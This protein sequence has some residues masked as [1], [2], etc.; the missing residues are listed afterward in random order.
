MFTGQAI[1][2]REDQRL[3]TGQGSYTD[4]VSLPGS[5]HLVFVRSPHAHARILSIDAAAAR[6]MAGVEA[7]VTGADVAHLPSTP[8]WM[9]PP[10]ANAPATHPLAQDRVRYVGE[11]VAAVLARD[12]YLARDAADAIE[13]EYEP[14]AAV[15]DPERALDGGSPRIHDG[16]DSNLAFR[17]QVGSDDVDGALAAADEV[18]R[19]RIDHPRVAALPLEPRAVVARYDAFNDSLEVVLST[20]Y[21]HSD[22][23][24]LAIVLGIPETKVRVITRD[25][26]GAFGA[27]GTVY[28]EEAIAAY[29]AWTRRCAVAWQETRSENLRATWHGRGHQCD[30]ALGVQR[31]GTIAALDVRVVSD[32]GAYLTPIGA[33]PT[34]NITGMACG[35]YRI[36]VVRCSVAAV[37]TNR[38]PIAPYRGAGRPE[39][40]FNLERAIDAAARVLGLDPAEMRRRNFIAADAFPYRTPTGHVYDSGDYAPALDKALALAGYEQ[41]RQEQQR[42]RGQG[43]YLGIGIC[44]F[45]EPSGAMLTEFGEVRV[46]RSGKATV[47]TGSSPHGQGLYTTFAQIVADEL[48]LPMEDVAVL[49]GDTAVVAMGTGT[50]GSRSGMLGGSA[51]RL[52]AGTVKEKM[53]AVAANLLEARAEDVELVDGRFGVAGVPA[54]A[55]SFAEVAAA[56]HGGRGLSP[57]MEPGL[58]A[59]HNY[60]AAGQAYPF[61]SHVAVVE[62]DAAS[63]SIAI[64]RYIGVDDAGNI[65]NP[66]LAGGQLHGGLAQ[67]LGQALFEE[68]AYDDSGQLLSGTL[69]DYAAPRADQMPHFELDHT[70]T[71][72]PNNPLGAKGVGEA[73][74]VAAP[75]A[76]VNAVLDALAPLGVTDLDMP[77]T[78]PKVW[79]AIDRARG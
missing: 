5:L 54:K 52:A 78:P 35:P 61:G 55:L 30:V 27:K 6:A 58:A 34:F 40:T 21:A 51:A 71:P 13:V 75:P 31:D 68:V 16:L 50:F 45:V 14:L 28:P 24:A 18:V 10:G 65:L 76:I 53:L 19:L 72:S 15:T 37:F 38:T 46:E 8:L 62:V 69:M 4:D 23:F 29:L 12:P 3:I 20:Q 57:D 32:I 41:W 33:G 9:R 59:S 2:R 77:L 39:A 22:R 36:G 47:L 25:V 17:V 1:P 79:A 67:G 43:R 44:S 74:A 11:A 70:V 49:H 64:L 48:S 42:L 63:G 56:A 7:V 26:G 73:G 60:K 66:L